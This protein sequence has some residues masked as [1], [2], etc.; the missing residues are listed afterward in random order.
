MRKINYGLMSMLALLM[1]AITS[2]GDAERPSYDGPNYILFSDTLTVLAVQNNE[3]VFDIP[4]A[5]TEACSYDRIVAVEVID[6]KS[7]AIEGKHYTI[8]S[9][10]VTIKAGERAA[11]VRIRG[12]YDAIAATDSLGL[13]LRL[14][15]QQADQ[16]D[17]YE[18]SYEAKVILQKC[19]PFDINLF[20]GYAVLTS[21]Y[22][23]EFMPNV[24]NRL[25]KAVIDPEE[26]N[27]VIMKDFFYD[28]YDVKIRFTTNDILNPLIEM[29]EQTFASTAEAFGTNYGDGYLHL[30][31]PSSGVS[32]Y[33][34]CEQFIFQ[35]FTLYV[36]GM[37]GNNVVGTFAS[38]IEWV[39]NDEAKRLYLEGSMLVSETVKT[40]FEKK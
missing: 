34:T 7:N 40:D 18:K 20:N 23:Q 28:G 31:Q 4:V 17:L 36:P 13:T 11:N 35:Y 12:N 8:E 29:D 21:T 32:Y 15:T 33:S 24:D 3:E 6:K 37:A 25:I 1:C 38:A 39:S 19:C 30:Y 2:C 5:A 14:L 9:N 16:W 27:T 26:E 22:M 10:T